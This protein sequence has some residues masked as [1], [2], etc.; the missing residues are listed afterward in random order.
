V[1][2]GRAG[3]KIEDARLCETRDAHGSIGKYARETGETITER[4]LKQ[5][6]QKRLGHCSET[7]TT[8]LTETRLDQ[9]FETATT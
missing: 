2:P 8:T 3:A 5:V 9:H 1:T 4:A 7:V 6:A